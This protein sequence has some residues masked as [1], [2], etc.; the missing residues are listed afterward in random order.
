MIFNNKSNISSKS[1]TKSIKNKL[2]LILFALL[3]IGTGFTWLTAYINK[4]ELKEA[5]LRETKIAASSINYNQ[6]L[7]LRGDSSDITAENYLLLKKQLQ[8]Q[9]GELINSRFV[10]L[11]GIKSNRVFFYVDSEPFD[12][13]DL[14]LPGSVYK[15]ASDLLRNVFFQKQAN[16]EGPFTDDWGTWVSGLV[17]IINPTNGQVVAVFGTDMS[18]EN[19]NIQI[20]KE[21]AVPVSLMLFALGFVFVS[22]M[23]GQKA[24]FNRKQSE[25]LSENE[26]KF[27]KMFTSHNAVMLLIE[28]NTGNITDANA[29]AVNFYD[30]SKEKLCSM[31]ISEINCL[32]EE[33]IDSYRQKAKNNEQNN[34]IFPHKL[35]NGI[36]KIVEVHSSIIETKEQSLLFSIIHDITEK[37]EAENELKR[38]DIFY[39]NLLNEVPGIIYQFIFSFEG[40]HQFPYIS[41][42]A[43]LIYGI[44]PKDIINDASLVFSMIHPDDLPNFIETSIKAN[45]DFTNWSGEFRMTLPNKG[46]R[47]IKA[48]S[49]PQRQVDG[50][51]LWT[52][53]M[54]DITEQRQLETELF[55]KE[56]SFEAI[57]AA[58]PD[59]IGISDLNGNLKFMSDTLATMFGISIDQKHNFIG[60]NVYEFIDSSSHQALKDNMLKLFSG[61]K[62]D[63]T[64]YLAIK[65][66]KT[67]FFVD[68]NSSILYNEFGSPKEILFIERDITKRKLIESKLLHS[69]ELL[70]ILNNKLN[71]NEC[72]NDFIDCVIKKT[73]LDAVAI[74]F[75]E[76]EDFP[77]FAQKGFPDA[78]LATENS[79]VEHNLCGEICK[80][81]FGNPNLECTCGLVIS[82]KID[83]NNSL[84]TKGG[85]FWSNNTSPI[86]EIPLDQDPRNKPR[87]ICMH[88]GYTSLAIIPIRENKQIVGTL[89]LNGIEAN[90]FSLDMIEF[91][92][93][94]CFTI[95]LRLSQLKAKES[96]EKANKA[97]SEFLANMSHEIRTPLNGVIGFS[98]L[99]LKTSLTTTQLKYMETVNYSAT[100]LLDLINDILDFSKIEAGKLELNPEKIDIYELIKQ[101]SEV[102]LYK[103]N[104]KGLKLI[105]DISPSVHRFIY[106]D[107]IRLRQIIINLLSNSVKFTEKGKIQINVEMNELENQDNEFVFS[108]SDTGIG[109]PENKHK[110]IFESF[111]QADNSTTRQYGGTGLGLSISRSLIAKM[112]SKIQLESE[113]GKGSR[114]FFKIKLPSEKNKNNQSPK[115]FSNQIDFKSDFDLFY[116][117]NYSVLIVDDYPT[118]LML[119]KAYVSDIFPNSKIFTAINGKEAIDLYSEH[120]PDIILMDIQI[121]IMNGFEATIE[122]RKIEKNAD[123]HTI[124][125]ALSAGTLLGEKEK[126]KI[127]GMDD[128]IAKPVV[129]DA[130]KTVIIKHLKTI[131]SLANDK[132]AENKIE[133]SIIHFDK[134]QMMERV[135]NNVDFYNQMINISLETLP[136]SIFELKKAFNDNKLE[137]VKF[138]AHAIKGVASGSSF[139]LLAHYALQLENVKENSFEENITLIDLLE[140]ELNIVTKI[141][142]Q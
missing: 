58:S 48:A 120:S 125:I 114:F 69:N 83:Y 97:K 24:R 127:A 77:Y 8:D 107:P 67:S 62:I 43:S 92:E 40:N 73:G 51:I 9:K 80:D 33:D 56:T 142:K 32:S 113:E 52:G 13:K 38:K 36:I 116:A 137:I 72:L 20:I 23:L 134:K 126:C 68:V 118:N 75:K 6:I 117:K 132:S 46:L 123:K 41:Q 111:T 133:N 59:G 57:I 35:A 39:Q 4:N 42:N 17:P 49:S 63:I 50:T 130:L 108:V 61:L 1:D 27:R 129:L 115:E 96:A 30:Y 122:I 106:A 54:N 16:I 31:H 101:I 84:F 91:Y 119:A 2:S 37:V 94:I 74:R 139:N 82:E 135:M 18:S 25:A 98:D 136:E 60:R 29:A 21:C 53:F 44:L 78:F 141:V 95:G 14:S 64:E 55:N 70:N 26:E 88:N 81:E 28:P 19:W 11:M 104:E 90:H 7:S 79:I 89:Q 34:F 47:W 124:I 138:C 99:L 22:F 5:I 109:I 105:V 112:G 100:S 65:D 121:P 93:G 45:Q 71:F 76:G 128:F 103:I 85:S 10:Y 87:N 66:D 102:V 15:E 3:I 86:L 140:K 131:K 110:Q 12:S